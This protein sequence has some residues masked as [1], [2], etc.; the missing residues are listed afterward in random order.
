MIRNGEIYFN[1]KSSLDL[2][3]KLENYPIIPL[4]SEEYEKI[5]VEGRN[6]SLILNKNT[7]PDKELQFVFTR[8]SDEIENLDEIYDWLTIMKDNKLFYGRNDRVYMVKKIEIGDFEQEFKTFGEIE[9]KFI[10]E[11]FLSDIYEIEHDI[12]KSGFYFY[13]T[14]TAPADSIIKVYGSGNIQITIDEEVMQILDVDEYVVIDS[15]LMQVRDK[16]GKSKDFDTI[17]DFIE[18]EN[19]KHTVTFSSNVTKVNIKYTTK[20]K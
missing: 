9:V 4:A 8:I 2:N 18:L 13:Y 19:G 10:C 20:Y 14:G 7:Y 16:N 12:I 17:G 11:P 3:M 15:K 1:N 5:T 6:G